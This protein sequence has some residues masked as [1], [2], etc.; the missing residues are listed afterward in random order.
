MVGRPRLELAYNEW[1]Q[2]LRQRWQAAFEAGAFLDEAGP[3]A[4]KRRQPV[5]P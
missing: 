4:H 2:E 5:S 1:P 3:G